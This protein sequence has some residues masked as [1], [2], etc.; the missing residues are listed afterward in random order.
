M[1]IP[2][3]CASLYVAR[4]RVYDSH[5]LFQQATA[6]THS[7][8]SSSLLDVR[9]TTTKTREYDTRLTR[10]AAGADSFLCHSNPYMGAVEEPFDAIAQSMDAWMSNMPQHVY[11]AMDHNTVYGRDHG[12]YFAFEEMAH[13]SELDC[14]GGTCGDD[15][16]KEVCG[17]GQLTTTTTTP[18]D[19][20]KQNNDR[21]CIVY[22]IGGNNHWEF[23]LDILKRTPCQVHTFD[24]T[25]STTRFQK[26]PDDRLHFHHVCL[27]IQNEAAPSE[28]KGLEKCGETWTLQKMQEE[29]GQSSGIDLFKM[30]IEGWEWPLI[31]SWPELLVA[32]QS[33]Y[34]LPMQILVEIHYM[35]PF[36]DLKPPGY[37]LS[38]GW[39]FARD[40]VLLQAKLLRMGYA[41]VNRDDNAAC[42]HCTELTLLRVRC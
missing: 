37:A 22:S 38:V 11:R 21:T 29:L 18:L 28:C 10:S 25:G 39:R 14:V 15:T 4:P 2:I 32:P 3:A 27:G 30:D 13:C 8:F 23:E 6:A 1:M 19:I 34:P 24:C 7:T 17:L 26:P 42:F 9:T 12:R 20:S 5:T 40:M 36:T 33:M 41:V 16:S 31:E 35:T